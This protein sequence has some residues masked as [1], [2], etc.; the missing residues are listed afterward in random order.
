MK[1]WV[2]AIGRCR[3]WWLAGCLDGCITGEGSLA[4]SPYHRL[5]LPV[6]VVN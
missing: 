5:W 4:T 2:V 3:V 6:S 1:V